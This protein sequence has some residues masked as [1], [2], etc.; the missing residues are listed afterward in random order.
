LV[1][2]GGEPAIRRSGDG[3]RHGINFDAVVEISARN[4]FL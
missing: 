3:V 1:R 4:E 2:F